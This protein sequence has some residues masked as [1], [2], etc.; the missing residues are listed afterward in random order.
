M[1]QVAAAWIFTALWLLKVY[2]GAYTFNLPAVVLI[3]L[4]L[5]APTS[6]SQGWMAL[7]IQGEAEPSASGD[8]KQICGDLSCLHRRSGGR[9]FL[10]AQ[11]HAIMA[12]RAFWHG[13]A[14]T[15]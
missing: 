9:A 10:L 2:V 14:G 8:G 7:A 5:R 11:Q 1:K 3:E 13:G 4:H 12:A 15:P 6:R